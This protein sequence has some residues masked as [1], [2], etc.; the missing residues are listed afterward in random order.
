MFHDSVWR[1]REDELAAGQPRAAQALA[2]RA[3]TRIRGALDSTLQGSRSEDAREDSH[4][5]GRS[6]RIMKCPG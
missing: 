3:G 6:S 4:I 1:D 5:H 2:P